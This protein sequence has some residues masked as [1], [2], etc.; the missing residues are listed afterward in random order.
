MAAG[1]IYVG[2]VDRIDPAGPLVLV[3]QLAPRAPF[4]PLTSLVPDLGVGERVAVTNL[5]SASNALI[6]LGRMPGRA[7][8][9]AEIPGLANRL[10]GI[11]ALNTAQNARLTAIETLNS[12]QDGRL[13]AVE[14]R[15]ATL[16]ASTT[17][18]AQA[19]GDL[20]AATAAG[21][22]RR[23]PA[24][25]DNLQVLTP[26]STA[27]AGLAWKTP[28]ALPQ[29]LTGAT[30]AGRYVGQTATGG[31]PTSGTF[32]VGDWV[33]D[34]NGLVWVCSVA[35]SPGTWASGA[36]SR[37]TSAESSIATNTAA[38]A[39]LRGDTAGKVT[40]KGDLLAGIGAGVLAR[41]AVGADGLALVGS[42]AAATGLAYADVRGLPVGGGLTGAT[43]A[44]RFVGSTAAGPPTTGTFAVGDYVLDR[45]TGDL[46]TCTAAGTPGTWVSPTVSGRQL[47]GRN[48]RT[49]STAAGAGPTSVLSVRA[50]V[51]AGRSYLCMLHTETF[52]ATANTQVQHDIRYTTTDVEPTTAA[53]G[54]FRC[55]VNMPQAN[56][57]VTGVAM[58]I[59]DAAASGFLRLLHTYTRVGS[60][61]AN[62]TVGAGATFPTILS[63]YDIGATL[64]N[65]GTIY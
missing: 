14:A 15:A 48:I 41:L 22:L 28:L 44:A 26:D 38:I 9:Q 20:L 51:V 49:T 30:A 6:I 64:A 13:T 10:S 7:P 61:A 53:T 2:T 37:L 1:M 46:W 27:T 50:P 65:S 11:E 63:V 25:T 58:G 33:R 39:T 55:E 59:F 35:G 45:A 16:E 5:G 12:T 47:V 17:G 19:K 29:P 40:A 3:P 18:Q 52:A 62:V 23:I 54:L 57:P 42:A 56:I 60:V 32:L 43:A 4:G 21:V 24:G 34:V 8:T 36:S 31:A